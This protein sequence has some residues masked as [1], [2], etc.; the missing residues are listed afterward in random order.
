MYKSKCKLQKRFAFWNANKNVQWWSQRIFYH[1]NCAFLCLKNN[2][3]L[4]SFEI[5]CRT[6][7]QSR[8]QLPTSAR[9]KSLCF[10]RKVLLCSQLQTSRT[11]WSTLSKNIVSCLVV[12]HIRLK[13]RN[14]YCRQSR[15]HL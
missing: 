13:L 9:K 14:G 8:Q 7:F 6:F 4:G 11:P 1:C 2:S 15:I 10:E 5:H 3:V 12:F